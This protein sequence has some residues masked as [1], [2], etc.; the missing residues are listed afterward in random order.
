M[1]DKH[2]TQLRVSK[3]ILSDIF[4]NKEITETTYEYRINKSGSIV[5]N[6]ETSQYFN[7]ATGEGGSLISLYAREN[8]ISNFEAY[9]LL[10]GIEAATVPHR[11]QE[12]HQ[13]EA[14]K[15][16][17]VKY[18]NKLYEAATSIKGTLA[19]QYL[20]NRCLNPMFFSPTFK[21]GTSHKDKM[22][23]APL[24]DKNFKFTGI[25]RILLDDNANK[26]T[27][28]S[29]GNVKSNYI[30]LTSRDLLKSKV[31][32][33]EGIEDGLSVVQENYGISC[34]ATTGATFL[35]SVEL[36]EQVE[37]VVILMD[38]DEASEKAK[39]Q[40]FDNNINRFKVMSMLNP[41]PKYKDFNEQLQA[42]K[43]SFMGVAYDH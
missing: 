27:K 39:M 25:H 11:R 6:K 14:I 23:I 35:P 4:P 2:Y 34:I 12:Y 40:F 38:N 20:V 15:K 22:L 41:V 8:N 30:W 10:G 17:L 19:E 13:P 29:L 18:S 24:Q 7:F 31:Y 28:K 16:D 43:G 26:V 33:A 32:I 5:V 3:D 36:P 9:K 42:E 1:S 37:E 21:Y